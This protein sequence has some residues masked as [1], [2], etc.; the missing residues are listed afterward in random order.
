MLTYILG[1]IKSL[2]MSWASLFYGIPHGDPYVAFVTLFMVFC[3]AIWAVQKICAHRIE[4][5]THRFDDSFYSDEDRFKTYC[6][7]MNIR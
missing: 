5:R 4:K 3:I 7:V 1:F 6:K 2:W